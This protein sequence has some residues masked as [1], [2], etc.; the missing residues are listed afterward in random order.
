MTEN[1]VKYPVAIGGY[2]KTG[3]ISKEE[4]LLLSYMLNQCDRET[5][6]IVTN[7]RL[8]SIEID[9]DRKRVSNLL[10]SLKNKRLIRNPDRS[11]TELRQNRGN[12]KPYGILLC[13][14]IGNSDLDRAKTELRQSE[15][16]AKTDRVDRRI[17]EDRREPTETLG[18]IENGKILAS[19]RDLDLERDQDPSPLPNSKSNTTGARVRSNSHANSEEKA[20]GEEVLS[21]KEEEA[22]KDKSDL[23][24]YVI[25]EFQRIF[26]YGAPIEINTPLY[27]TLVQ[28]SEFRQVAVEEALNAC[29]QAMTDQDAKKRPRKASWILNRL[30]DPETFGVT[31]PKEKRDRKSVV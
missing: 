17:P 5:G 2:L 7:S 1:W 28:I 30:K 18:K 3:L 24:G 31:L 4:F 9:V 6:I 8:L 19:E 15:D 23:L 22:E 12:T 10:T 13:D 27:D 21:E 25:V 29:E 26:A 20:E 16:R 11:K 14:A